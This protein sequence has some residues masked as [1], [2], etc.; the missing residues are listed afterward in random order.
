M[1]QETKIESATDGEK[2]TGGQLWLVSRAFGVR[3]LRVN[4][5]RSTLE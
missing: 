1:M 3:H 2:F 4:V 5:E